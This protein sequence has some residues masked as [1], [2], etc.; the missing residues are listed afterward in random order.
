MILLTV[1]GKVVLDSSGTRAGSKFS[2]RTFADLAMRGI[3]IS[4]FTLARIALLVSFLGF[5]RI[6]IH[7]GAEMEA[8]QYHFAHLRHLRVELHAFFA[9]TAAGI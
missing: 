5:L 2:A 4:F 8:V 7:H 1:P 9:L 6:M 3:D